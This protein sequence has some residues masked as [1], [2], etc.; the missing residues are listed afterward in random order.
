MGYSKKIEKVRRFV[1]LAAVV[2]LILCALLTLVFALIYNFTGSAFF[3]T[4]WK[5][6]A[7][8]MIFVPLIM[9]GMLLIHK[10]TTKNEKE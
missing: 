5:A 7:W 6:S 2:V 9:Y 8:A 10:V 3:A 4:A 1:A